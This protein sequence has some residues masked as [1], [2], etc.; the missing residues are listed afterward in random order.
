MRYGGQG[1]A[2]GGRP[3]QV[4]HDHHDGGQRVGQGYS[5]QDAAD[6]E[7]EAFDEWLDPDNREPAKIEELLR[8]KNVKELKSYRC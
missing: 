2:S 7:P 3:L 1:C 6:S 8:T 5:Q 4:L